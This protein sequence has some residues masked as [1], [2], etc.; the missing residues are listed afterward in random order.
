MERTGN[1]KN[2]EKIQRRRGLAIKHGLKHGLAGNLQGC[3]T[4]PTPFSTLFYAASENDSLLTLQAGQTQSAG[5]S[6]KA[7]PG[8]TPF[9]ASPVTGSYS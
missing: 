2:Y 9:L 3:W 4:S 5:M 8:F 1:Q 6:S 7:V